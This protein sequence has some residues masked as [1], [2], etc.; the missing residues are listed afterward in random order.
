MACGIG[1]SILRR[2]PRQC[3]RREPRRAVRCAVDAVAPPETTAT[4]RSTRPAARSAAA[5]SPYAVAALVPTIATARSATRD[6][7]GSDDPQRQR[8]M[9][10]PPQSGSTPGNAERRERPFGMTLRE[11]SPPVRRI[12]SRSRRRSRSGVEPQSAGQLVGD[13]SAPDAP[14]ASTG[15]TRLIRIRKLRARRLGHTRQIGPAR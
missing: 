6:P 15:P 10:F 13:L 1:T 8:W 12:K 4:S 5:Y 3:S 9:T 14:A 11:Q 7:R 2:G